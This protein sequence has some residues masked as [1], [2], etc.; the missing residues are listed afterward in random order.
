MIV[1]IGNDLESITRVAQVLERQ[2]AFLNMILTKEEV[3]AAQQRH[4]KHYA[5]FIAGRFSAKE[6]FS[7]ATGYGIGQEVHWHD[8]AILNA[9]NGRP[10]ITV[11]N[12]PYTVRVAITHSDNFVNTIVVIEKLSWLEKLKLS[13]TGGRGV[14]Q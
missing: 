2:P 9:D 7:K 14:L 4:G 1:G 11:K 12:F 8:I 5:E 3:Q 6:A 13:L 10:I